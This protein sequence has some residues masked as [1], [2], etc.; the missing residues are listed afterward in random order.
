MTNTFADLGLRTELVDTVSALGY[1]VPTPIQNEA[2][3]ALLA[4]KDL[5]GQAATG[6]G[7][8]AAFALPL[9][10]RLSETAN[11]AHPKPSILVLVPTRELAMQVGE[12]MKNYGKALRLQVLAVFG[13]QS[14]DPQLRALKRGVH[15][16]VA[17]PG[18]ALDHIR[19]KT[20]NLD[21]IEAVVLD[22]ADEM[23]DMG[24]A[25]D[26]E[27]ILEGLP[28]ER[29]TALFSATMPPRIARIAD[30]HL[31]DPVK[32]SIAREKPAPGALPK[33]RQCVYL[34]Q[35][36]HKLAA[37]SRVLDFENPGSAIIFCRTRVDVDQLADALGGRGYAVETLHGGMS[38]QERDRVMKRVRGQSANLLIATDVAARGLDI[39]HL[40]HV[41]NFDV[42]TS[43]DVYVHRIGRTG[44]A[45]REGTALTIADPREGRL[46]RNVEQLTGQRLPTSPIP[47]IEQARE[48]RLEI[49]TKS[50]REVVSGG[51]LTSYQKV[52]DALQGEFSK[53]DLV[54]AAVKLAHEA[55][56][57]KVDETVIPEL[58]S[59]RPRRERTERPER[60]RESR[61][62]GRRR[63]RV[64]PEGPMG[65]V[66]VDAG[67]KD[68]IR[69]GD[70]VGVL[71]NHVGLNPEVIGAIK[72]AD[73]FSLVDV[74]EEH[75]QSVINTLHAS[76]IR[77][78]KVG[79]RRDRDEEEGTVR[80]SERAQGPREA[81][82]ESTRG[83]RSEGRRPEGR[84]GRPPKSGKKFVRRER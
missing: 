29:Q 73:R 46:L 84:P 6:T 43:P 27:A 21:E 5:L 54:L 14:F 26:L 61:P 7:K 34:V 36:S 71:T 81:T 63:E 42:P 83:R 74:P 40:T 31:V 39:E 70:I 77:G 52:I 9:L 13:G 69:P 18:R 11:L 28:K 58:D 56:V 12:A 76:M 38:Q 78:V 66:Y 16:V 33:I 79:V 75:M 37:L 19:R 44:R 49:T 20:L 8:T 65:R 60:D 47:T 25:E 4:G 22:E 80:T 30:T 62:E 51:D 3:P 82:R 59:G 17:T 67:R 41:I 53:G 68:K 23:L 57:G 24:F 1:S 45:G 55:T 64:R 72:I 15:V 48:K 32:I 10:N 50:L 35:R 2:I